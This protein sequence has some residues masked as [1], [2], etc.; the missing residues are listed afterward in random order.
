MGR[1]NETKKKKER[2]ERNNFFY[3][4]LFDCVVYTVLFY[5]VVCKNKNWKVECI[6]K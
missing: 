2:R 6:I 1:Q 5:W 4:I 3:F